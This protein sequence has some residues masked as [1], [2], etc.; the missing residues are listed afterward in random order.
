MSPDL[1][2]DRC[3]RCAHFVDDP[4]RLERMFTG[5]TILSSAWGSTRGDQG[6][7]TLH[8][9]LLQP[10]MRCF[11]FVDRGSSSS[12]RPCSSRRMEAPRRR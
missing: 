5:M 7:C 6:L 1:V 2:R 10:V 12:S 9:R 4:L 3:G 11:R 8:E